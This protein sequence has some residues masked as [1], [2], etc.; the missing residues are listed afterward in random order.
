MLLL[1]KEMWG[2]YNLVCEGVSSRIE[3]ANEILKILNKDKVVNINEV[4]SS[5]FSTLE[6]ILK[7]E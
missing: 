5:F 4:D 2:K 3:V 6:P 1:Q 7:Q